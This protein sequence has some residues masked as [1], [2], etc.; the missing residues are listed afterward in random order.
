VPVM[1]S[2]FKLCPSAYLNGT[3][4]LT[5]TSLKSGCPVNFRRSI[6]PTMEINAVI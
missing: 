2:V 5:Q 6:S 4:K 3:D 1:E